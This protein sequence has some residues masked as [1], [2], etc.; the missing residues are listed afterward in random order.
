ML[1]TDQRK[2]RDTDSCGQKDHQLL[3]QVEDPTIKGSIKSLRNYGFTCATIDEVQHPQCV[4]CN[5]VLA[6]KSLKPANMLRQLKTKHPSLFAKAA[7]VSAERRYNW[8][9]KR[10]F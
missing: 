6:H 9:A 8:K 3:A 1:N 10:K 5:E 2:G 4:M 7:D